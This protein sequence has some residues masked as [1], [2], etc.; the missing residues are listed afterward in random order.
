MI[1]LEN[2]STLKLTG[3]DDYKEVLTKM[4]S[5]QDKSVQYQILSF[6]HSPWFVN[7]YGREAYVE[8]LNELKSQIN[9]VLIWDNPD[10]SIGTYSGF[11]TDLLKLRPKEEIKYPDSRNNILAYCKQSYRDFGVKPRPAQLE[12]YNRF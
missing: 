6:K 7:K 9:K 4:F 1:V 11:L 12:A 2:Y 5:Y 8:R 3:W 10:G